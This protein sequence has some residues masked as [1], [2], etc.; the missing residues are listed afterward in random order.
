MRLVVGL[1]NPGSE[2]AG[3]RHNIGF[4]V[5]DE[6]ARR[7]GTRFGKR[8]AKSLVALPRAGELDGRPVLAKP[9]TYMNLSGDAVRLLA[10]GLGPRPEEILVVYDDIDLPLGRVR[11]R[12]RGSAGGHRGVASIIE[13]LGTDAFPRLRLGVGRPAGE[14]VDY[15]LSRFTVDEQLAA[16]ELVARGADAA[17]CAVEEGLAAAMNRY[18]R[19]G[20]PSSRTSV[21]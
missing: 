5:V 6:L 15:V 4:A 9:Q 19:P 16:D 7:W 17:A 14:T 10:R 13:R 2:Y 11:V 18:N 8:Q 21:P 20:L 12:E 3:T 1:G